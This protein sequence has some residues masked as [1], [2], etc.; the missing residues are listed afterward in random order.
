MSDAVTLIHIRKYRPLDIGFPAPGAYS[1]KIVLILPDPDPTILS[2]LAP[3]GSEPVTLEIETADT[4]LASD[5]YVMVQKNIPTLEKLSKDHASPINKRFA[6][7]FI[8]SMHKT[9]NSGNTKIK[10]GGGIDPLES[11]YD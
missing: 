11:L 6:Q 7:H 2:R 3:G 4:V 10:L 8:T 1:G 5:I 9:R